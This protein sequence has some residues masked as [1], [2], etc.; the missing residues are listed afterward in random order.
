MLIE[1]GNDRERTH[2][3]GGWRELYR[4]ERRGQPS[5]PQRTRPPRAPLGWV[6]MLLFEQ[7]RE[8]LLARPRTGRYASDASVDDRDYG[9]KKSQRMTISRKQQTTNVCTTDGP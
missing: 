8:L 1:H 2:R 7:R 4:R 5:G 6:G 9:G 3:N